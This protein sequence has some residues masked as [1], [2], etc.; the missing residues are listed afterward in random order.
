MVMAVK[1]DKRTKVKQAKDKLVLSAGKPASNAKAAPPPTKP[2]AANFSSFVL[3]TRKSLG[4][5]QSVFGRLIG[6][7]E[8]S[9]SGWELGKPVSQASFRRVKEL[10]RLAEALE[11]S[12]KKSYIP[13]WLVTPNEGLA[14]ISPIEALDRGENDRLWRTV[15]Y[16][17]SGAPI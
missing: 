1:A 11:R 13:T 10:R 3:S 9:I 7:S 12:M 2:P 4:V 16:L 5:T 14:G 6:V 15:F 8:R 17:G